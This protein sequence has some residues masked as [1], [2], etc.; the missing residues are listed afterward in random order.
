MSPDERC[1]LYWRA[2]TEEIIPLAQ[3]VGDSIRFDPESGDE[4]EER[5]TKNPISKER[6]HETF[7]RLCSNIGNCLSAVSPLGDE[8]SFAREREER[9]QTYG[10]CAPSQN[11]M[12][13]VPKTML[14]LS[15]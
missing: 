15:S 14:S 3:S 8:W 2:E 11:K 4:P 9:G 6:K 10:N 1:G 12:E 5:R 7:D 13:N